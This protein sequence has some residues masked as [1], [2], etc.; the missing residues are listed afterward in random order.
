MKQYPIN[1]SPSGAILLGP[2]ITCD[3]FHR[4]CN[5][6]VQTHIHEDHM[7]DFDTSKGIQDLYMTEATKDLLVA[8]K[9][10]DLPYRQNIH[11]VTTKRRH[12]IGNSFLTVLSTG[13]MLGA[14]QVK[15]ELP[16]GVT[17]GYSGDFQWPMQ[18]IIRVDALIVDSTY[19]GPDCKRKYTQQEAEDRFIELAL[20][21]VKRGGLHIKSHRGTLHRALQA[22][23]GNLR[24]PLL[25]SPR[26]CEEVAVYRKHGYGIDRLVSTVSDEGKRALRESRY[27]RI[28]GKGDPLPVDPHGAT[29]LILSAFRT[30]PDN[31]VIVHSDKSFGVAL[32]DHADFEGTLEYIR[33]TGARFVIT[34]NHRGVHAI[35]LATEV[36]SRLGIPCVASEQKLSREWG[37]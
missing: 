20:K 21:A 10:A 32:T 9:N 29:T 30:Q 14:V 23:A 8:E 34:D 5:T 4:E 2:H 16:S 17:V 36:R 11:I 12:K 37:A 24:Y 33:A 18:E 13:H 31:P 27:V 6:R 7:E 28:Y 26:L 3:G 35:E 15:V 22:L 1:V 25:G 19:G